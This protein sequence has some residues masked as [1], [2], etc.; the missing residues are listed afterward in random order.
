MR[1]T[2]AAKAVRLLAG[3]RLCVELVEPHDG[4]IVASCRG[5]HGSYELGWDP[6]GALWWCACP[7]FGACSHLLALQLVVV[8]ERLA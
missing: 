7:A 2:P 6:G 1:E 8:P 5:D 4:R 3:Q